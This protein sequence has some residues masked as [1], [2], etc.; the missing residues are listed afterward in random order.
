M[1]RTLLKTIIRSAQRRPVFT[2]INLLGLSLGIACSFIMLRYVQQEW[3][4]DKHFSN[5]ERVFRVGTGFMNMG[6]FA[7]SQE[8]L[9]ESLLSFNDIEAATR[10]TTRGGEQPI[11]VGEETF[12]KEEI[13]FVDSTFFEVFAYAFQEGNPSQALRSPNSLSLIHIS[14]P[15]RPY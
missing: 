13:V 2:S 1:I 5:G 11:K 7:I 4:Y 3:S 12:M 10:L 15:T 14:E 9:R 6:P 8:I